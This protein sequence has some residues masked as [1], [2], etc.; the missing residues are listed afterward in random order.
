MQYTPTIRR[1][2]YS[3]MVHP[4]SLQLL[5]SRRELDARFVLLSQSICYCA[6]VRRPNPIH[7]NNLG[8]GNDAFVYF[9]MSLMSMDNKQWVGKR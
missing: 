2:R 6:H 8:G 9:G 5:W 7:A 4:T 3:R 1:P